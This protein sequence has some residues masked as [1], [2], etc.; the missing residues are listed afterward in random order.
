M[1]T[2]GTHTV[3][4]ESDPRKSYTVTVF[5]G[6]SHCTCPAWQRSRLPS[7]ERACKHIEEVT[8]ELRR[9][10]GHLTD[11][12][13][14]W[15]VRELAKLTDKPLREVAEAVDEELFENEQ[16]SE[17]ELT[18]GNEVMG[19]LETLWPREGLWQPGPDAHQALILIRRAL[20]LPLA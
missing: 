8:G 5:E 10:D 13:T 9:G 20:K 7:Q 6:H 14:A 16:L 18:L 12:E 2:L 3:A 11:Y 4:S 17:Y 1:A 15:L 19:A